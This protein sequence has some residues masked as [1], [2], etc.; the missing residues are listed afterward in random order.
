M[1]KSS[2]KDK[3]TAKT[4]KP[5]TKRQQWSALQQ[6]IL[7]ENWAQYDCLFDISSEEFHDKQ[8][9]QLAKEEISKATGMP[10][11]YS[12]HIEKKYLF[13]YFSCQFVYLP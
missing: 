4:R 6:G 13:A 2:K 12:T 11:K 8:A 1:S 7:A 5:Y 9:R 10:S 3:T